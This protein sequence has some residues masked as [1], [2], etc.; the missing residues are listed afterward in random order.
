MK[1]SKDFFYMNCT[2]QE[3]RKVSQVN[4][5]ACSNRK[6]LVYTDDYVNHELHRS[7]PRIYRLSNGWGQTFV[8][9]SDAPVDAV[10]YVYQDSEMNELELFWE[11]TE[12]FLAGPVLERDAAAPDRRYTVYSTG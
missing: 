6:E 1:Y 10:L 11:D 12:Y 9:P 2:Y 3:I 7:Q 5:K 4:V 8:Q